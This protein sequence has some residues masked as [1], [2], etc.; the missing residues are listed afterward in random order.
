[1]VAAAPRAYR[2][3]LQLSA[4]EDSMRVSRRRSRVLLAA[5]VTIAAAA[6]GP[7]AE[8]AAGTVT[9]TGDAGAPVALGGPVPIRYI[10][11]DVTVTPGAGE[12]YGFAVTGPTGAAASAGLSCVDRGG[13]K[14]LVN[15]F[16]NGVYTVTV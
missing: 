1:M 12:W 9:G 2:R 14:N 10:N 13:S 3:G 4:T 15:Y 5:T 7:A 6:I 8:S 11:P 16:G